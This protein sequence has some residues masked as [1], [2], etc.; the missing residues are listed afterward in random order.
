MDWEKAYRDLLSNFTIEESTWQ[1]VTSAGAELNVS[2]P[3]TRFG[4]AV[5]SGALWIK[6]GKSGPKTRLSYGG[7]GVSG[8]FPLVPS[9]LNFSFSMPDM[10]SAGTI[11]KLPYA[12]KTL[13]LKELKGGFVMLQAGIDA[14]AGRAKGVMLLG[15]DLQLAG[16]AGPLFLS[17]LMVTSNACVRFGGMYASVLPFNVGATA[18]VGM[19]Q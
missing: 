1:F 12:G 2:I 15:G 8:G 18:Y 3:E 6:N 5:T 13:S 11:Y 9:P 10:P 7:P 19:I 14:G 16:T 17:V 4:V